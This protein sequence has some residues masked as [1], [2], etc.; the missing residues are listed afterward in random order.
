MFGFVAAG[1][2]FI[3]LILLL[4]IKITPEEDTT[5]PSKKQNSSKNAEAGKETKAHSG[6]SVR[7]DKAT[8]LLV[9]LMEDGNVSEIQRAVK[10]GIHLNQP[11]QDGQTVLM[12]AVKHNQDPEIIPF[13]IN[14][15][16]NVNAVDDKG[17]TALILAATFNPSPE[18]IK[19][20]LNC[21]ADKTI[22]DKSGKTAA[23]Y[24]NMNFDLHG[25]GIP[26]LLFVK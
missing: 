5:P 1:I 19:T 23:D 10:N 2:A 26:E 18:I 3:A 7:L 13:L 21:G 20:L 15:G 24:V 25:T 6:R 11:L 9:H 22:K 8:E 12:I 4:T 16:I 14:N 17:Q